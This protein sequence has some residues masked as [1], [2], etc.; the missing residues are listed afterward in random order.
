MPLAA[1]VDG[2]PADGLKFAEALGDA[3]SAEE[4]D[5]P[6]ETRTTRKQLS[7]HNETADLKMVLTA[8]QWTFPVAAPAPPR[9]LSLTGLEEAPLTGAAVDSAPKAEA[10]RDVAADDSAAPV[11]AI[12]PGN[13]QVTVESVEI[14]SAMLETASKTATKGSKSPRDPESGGK[15]EGETTAP[16]P[17][18]APPPATSAP[19][20]VPPPQT[21]TT[22][23]VLIPVPAGVPEAKREIQQA[24]GD[25]LHNSD[26]AK[27]APAHAAGA[28]PERVPQVFAFDGT[29][30]QET[31]ATAP[32]S[33]SEMQPVAMPGEKQ[34]AV[35]PAALSQPKGA[36]PLESEEVK[37]EQRQQIRQSTES[38]VRPA[39][40]PVASAAATPLVTQHTAGQ[41]NTAR[42]SESPEVVAPPRQ[43]LAESDL[44]AKAA[45]ASSITV[46]LGENHDDR[47]DI[48]FQHR[49]GTLQLAVRTANPELAQKLR[50]ELPGLS[51]SL[52]NQGFRSELRMDG[53]VRHVFEQTSAAARLTDDRAAPSAMQN[54]RPGNEADTEQGRQNHA[55]D[56]YAEDQRQRP[57]RRP[58]GEQDDQP[59]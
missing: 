10:N 49:D 36:P 3:T 37:G 32:A 4:A 57:R 8:P 31:P 27:A 35:P 43:V 1:P 58:Q 48:R 41:S 12:P 39:A 50:S 6:G 47:M 24:S 54:F 18:L 51:Q 33:R 25:A 46:Q 28:T 55:S 40:E 42:A 30:R 34:Q 56:W 5:E 9:S 13:G 59:S 45:P 23:P 52:G 53:A 2:A 19:A 21:A 22:P 11:P 7:Q 29:I 15:K 26:S 38:P 44:K 17:S 20:P 14:L 16:A